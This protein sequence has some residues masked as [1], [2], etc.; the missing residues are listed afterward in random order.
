MPWQLY[1]SSENPIYLLKLALSFA[2]HQDR[3]FSRFYL[4]CFILS[5]SFFFLLFFLST[6]TCRATSS[7][8]HDGKVLSP[9]D[10]PSIRVLQVYRQ[11]L[12]SNSDRAVLHDL[13]GAMAMAHGQRWV[14]DL[15]STEA[16]VN[17]NSATSIL[18]TTA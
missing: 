11:R 8:Q 18:V 15:S 4:I 10:S 3:I 13:A 1:G 5:L 9:E 16:R 17:S 12:Y 7:K 6:L 2:K 14:D